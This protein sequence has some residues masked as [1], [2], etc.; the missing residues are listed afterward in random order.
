MKKIAIL[1]CLKWSA[2]CSSINCFQAFNNK[3]G[4]F[5][6]YKNQEV[7]LAAFCRC[8]GCELPYYDD[9]DMLS[10]LNRLIKEQ[11][12]TVHLGLCTQLRDKVDKK[13]RVEC[14]KI[15]LISQYLEK[16]NVQVIRGTHA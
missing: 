8:N 1:T 11:V 3:E 2:P 6:I 7:Q 10:K 13:T 12:D 4:G 9:P 16:N 5:A 14:E 15:T